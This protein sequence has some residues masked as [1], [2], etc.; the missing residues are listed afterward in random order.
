MNKKKLSILFALMD[1]FPPFRVDVSVL[2]AQ[3][4]ASMGHQM[5]WVLQSEKECA[6]SYVAAYGGG[7]AF[8]GKTH[9]GVLFRH[10]LIKHIRGF[11]HDLTIVRLLL[12]RE[13]DFIQV[14]DK[15][16][17]AVIALIAAKL[18]GTPFFYWL[19]YPLAEESL[20]RYIDGTARYPISYL[21]RGKAFR[22]LLYKIIC[23]MAD[24]IFVQ[25]EQMR[26]DMM[27]YNIPKKKMT[28]VPMG[29]NIEDFP[30]KDIIEKALENKNEKKIILYLGTLIRVRRL[31]FL[32]RVL[33]MVRWAFPE[34]FLVFV[35]SGDDIED[36][37]LLHREAKRLS[38]D[39]AIEITGR[40]PF[41]AA[42]DLVKNADVCLSPFYPT[43]ILKS[44]SP[45]KLI[46]YMA[47]GKAVVANDHPEQ[48]KVIEESGAGL[49][50]E[51][52]E[53]KFSQ[54]IIKLIENP[55]ACIEMGIKGRKYVEQ[56]RSYDIIARNL[57]RTYYDILS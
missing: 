57:E 30:P 51:W 49:C 18:T 37:L 28:P 41:K 52:S 16:I 8:I 12:T 25:S 26:S 4:L 2:F 38:L 56:H 11:V 6:K 23:P 22:F 42:L 10:R 24:H 21:I 14:K 43:P 36:E 34:A 39:N 46:E 45:T 55:I 40:L 20:Q 50:V 27:M 17:T 35:G 47:M 32:I 53:E 29:I 1:T 7:T 3:K 33:N 9:T 44:T 15:F 31:D 5:D 13:Y 19:S 54:A 48:K